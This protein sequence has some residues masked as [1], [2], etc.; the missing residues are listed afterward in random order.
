MPPR[1]NAQEKVR[2][3]IHDQG[4]RGRKAVALCLKFLQ[5]HIVFVVS[6]V[7]ARPRVKVLDSGSP[8]GYIYVTTVLII[9]IGSPDGYMHVTTV[10]I[11]IIVP[12]T[13][14]PSC[15]LL[16]SPRSAFSS[17]LN[18]KSLSLYTLGIPVCGNS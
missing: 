6:I 12:L 3:K 2:G 15:L 5:D 17:Q 10:L 11:I 16:L 18:S 9:I 8:D 7:C 4:A 13:L 1:Q 14:F